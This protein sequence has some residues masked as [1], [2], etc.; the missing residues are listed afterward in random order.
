MCPRAESFGRRGVGEHA[1]QETGREGVTGAHGFH[2]RRRQ[3]GHLVH[4]LRGYRRRGFRTVLDDEDARAGQYLPHTR[5]RQVRVPQAPVL[6]KPHQNDRARAWLAVARRGLRMGRWVHVRV[7]LASVAVCW[8]ESRPRTAWMM[9]LMCSRRLWWRARDRQFLRWPMPCSTRMFV[10]GR[11]C[12]EL[13]RHRPPLAARPEP[14]DH[15]LK[16]LPQPLAVRAGLA[17]RQVRLD[18]LPLRVGQLHSPHVRR[19]TR[20][21]RATKTHPA[22]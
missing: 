17:D 22:D 20:P 10:D 11:P 13:C 16:L 7:P 9:S 5:R 15:A 6:V 2:H 19:P 21:D 14:P 1:G 12:T 3:R 8:W 18:E 4:A